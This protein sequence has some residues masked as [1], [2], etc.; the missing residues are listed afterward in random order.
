MSISQ[1]RSTAADAAVSTLTRKGFVPLGDPR[2]EPKL[3][4]HPDGKRAQRFIVL[5]SL[6]NGDNA[7]AAIPVDVEQL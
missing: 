5:M 1:P 3:F 6:A 2:S 7:I 4:W